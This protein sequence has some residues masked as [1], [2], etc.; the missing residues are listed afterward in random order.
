MESDVD[1]RDDDESILVGSMGVDMSIL[2]TEEDFEVQ[3]KKKKLKIRL[4][5]NY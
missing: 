5:K 1:E 3:P 2:D 4:K